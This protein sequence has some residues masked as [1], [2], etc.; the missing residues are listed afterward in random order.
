MVSDDQEEF[1][2]DATW[3]TLLE[4]T[5]RC[6]HVI[7][8]DVD[9]ECLSIFKQH[10]FEKLAQSGSAGNYKWGLDTGN[11]QDSWDP[12]AEPPSY[13]NHNDHNEGDTDYDENELEVLCLLTSKWV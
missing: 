13:W 2:L 4:R 11:H 8:N 5:G 10:L 3:T 7:H 12:H 9:L 1:I 6:T